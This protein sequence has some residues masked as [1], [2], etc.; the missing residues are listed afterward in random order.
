V[1][2]VVHP[3]GALLDILQGAKQVSGFHGNGS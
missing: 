2:L 3:L 1:T